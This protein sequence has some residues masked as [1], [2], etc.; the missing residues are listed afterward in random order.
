MFSPTLMPKWSKF[1]MTCKLET[2]DVFFLFC[3]QWYTVVSFCLLFNNQISRAG[4]YY[5]FIL[6]LIVTDL[7][8][9]RVKKRKKKINP[10][11]QTS[12]FILKKNKLFF[13]FFSW[14]GQEKKK[15]K[16]ERNHSKQ[17]FCDSQLHAIHSDGGYYPIICGFSCI[18]LSVYFMGVILFIFALI[19][20]ELVQHI[21]GLNASISGPIL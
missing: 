12:V 15:E 4:N 18:I 3:L 9:Q 14:K 17:M 19:I 13:F 21:V 1:L 5:P 20:L 10:N 11:P 16:K 8:T 2:C 7:F 6:E